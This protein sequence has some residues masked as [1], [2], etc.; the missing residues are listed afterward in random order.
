MQKSKK[1]KYVKNSLLIGCVFFLLFFGQFLYSQ[2]DNEGTEALF[3][4]NDITFYKSCEDNLPYPIIKRSEVRNVIL[5]IGDG[6]GINQIAAARIKGAGLD[7]K[8][9]MERIPITGIMRTHSANNVVTD[10]AA[11]GTAL[12]CGIKTNNDMVGMAAD[13]TKYANIFEAAQKKGMKTAILVT[14]EIVH[15][16][17]ATFAT[18]VRNRWMYARIAE[19]LVDS[20]INILF[21]GGKSYFIPKGEPNSRRKDDKNLIK[22]AEENGCRFI[23]TKQQ[24]ESAKGQYLLGLFALDDLTTKEPEPSIAELTRKAIEILEVR[25]EREKTCLENI[26]DGILNL[27]SHDSK[28]DSKTGFF[29]M[30]EGSQIDWACHKNDVNSCVRQTLLFDLAVKE[31]VDFAIRDRKTLVI[32]TADHETRGLTIA[33]SETNGKIINFIWA[34]N[35]LTGNFG[36]TDGHTGQPVVVFAFG[37]GA[38]N[39]SGTYDNTEIPKKIARLLGIKNFPQKVKK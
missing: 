12:A 14:S 32:V 13:G 7:G 33:E 6:M 15:A 28:D 29:M 16:T 3:D 26:I 22:K 21:G 2:T 5:L 17:P 38:E 37:P 23:E 4:V 35:D 8:L 25:Q 18:H 36:S 9:Y 31:A 19:Q 10:S 1:S 24:L 30:V 27:V 34:I 39:F 11:A 20:R